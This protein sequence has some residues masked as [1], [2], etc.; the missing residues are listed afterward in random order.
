MKSIERPQIMVAA[1][2]GASTL[3]AVVDAIEKNRGGGARSWVR[4]WSGRQR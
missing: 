4:C 3:E 2:G 1:S